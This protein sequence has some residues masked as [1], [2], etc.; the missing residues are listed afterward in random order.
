MTVSYQNL[1]GKGDFVED[2]PTLDP[3]TERNSSNV[4]EKMFAPIA[5]REGAVLEKIE[6]AKPES[7]N[8]ENVASGAAQETTTSQETEPASAVEKTEPVITAETTEEKPDGEV[9]TKTEGDPGKIDWQVES[10]KHQS[11]ADKLY[12]EMK[13]KNARLEE[14]QTQTQEMGSYKQMVDEFKVNPVE[15][16][17]KNVPELVEQ[18]RSY[19]DP[20]SSI[21]N[22]VGKYRKELITKFRESHG[23]DWEFNST[24]SLEPGTPSFRFKVALEDKIAQARSRYQQTVDQVRMAKDQRQRQKE[25]D[26]KRVMQEFGLDEQGIKK[27]DEYLTK[28]SPTYYNLAKLALIDKLVQQRID[29]LIPPG[30]APPELASS[31]AKKAARVEGEP[32]LSNDMKNVVARLGVGSFF[33]EM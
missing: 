4:M 20:I 2:A 11:R 1:G 6:S 17:T 29:A 28:T 30:Q 21:E 23:D 14:L 10:R 25:E 27:V 31:P 19:N 5:K 22:E 12:E 32:E 26:R 33:K 13:A 16:I 9:E 15:F 8:G 18:L 7:R 24:D 3:N